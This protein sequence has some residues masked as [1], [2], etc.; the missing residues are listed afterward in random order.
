MTLFDERPQGPKGDP[1]EHSDV[2][3]EKTHRFRIKTSST[4]VKRPMRERTGGGP[5][6]FV[7]VRS[8]LSEREREAET[9]PTA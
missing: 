6:I 1:F 4:F 2:Q 5:V 7:G 9:E 8:G 3:A